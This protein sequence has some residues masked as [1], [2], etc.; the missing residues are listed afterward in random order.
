MYH[1]L[2]QHKGVSSNL[3]LILIKKILVLN[4]KSILLFLDDYMILFYNVFQLKSD[5]TKVS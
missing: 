4:C 5:K 1:A 2:V 3:K